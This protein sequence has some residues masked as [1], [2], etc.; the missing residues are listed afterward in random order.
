MLKTKSSQQK[1][2]H[3]E[4]ERYRNSINILSRNSKANYSQ[5]F[6]QEHKQNILK[7]WIG[8][9]SIIHISTTKN[10]SINCTNIKN[11]EEADPF[12]LSSS[13]NKFFTNIVKK[14]KKKEAESNI[15]H[16]T[17]NYTNYLTNLSEKTFFLTSKSGKEV[18][19]II[20]T[21]NLRISIDPN[22]IPTKL[23]K[24]Y[25]RTISIPISNLINQSF[26]TWI[27]P[28]SLKFANA[29]LIFKNADPLECT[30][31][32]PISLTSNINKILEKLVH[33]HLYHFL[34]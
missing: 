27:F 13:F 24:K 33:K 12:V 8:I 10:R 30:N 5:N 19:D 11:V 25:S 32:W 1:M 17:K 29:I 22:S 15:V 18:E 26:V 21:L 3:N 14:K 7:T 31:Y 6:F 28:E 34:E 20:K 23:F 2:L 9:R 4:F 16:T